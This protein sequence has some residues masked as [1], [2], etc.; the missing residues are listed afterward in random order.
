[1]AEVRLIPLSVVLPP[2]QKMQ[3]TGEELEQ[4]EYG[5]GGEQVLREC[6]REGE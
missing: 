3:C 4:S 5:R 2:E 6:L 1:M